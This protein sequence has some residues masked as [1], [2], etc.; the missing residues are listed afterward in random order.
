MDKIKQVKSIKD[1]DLDVNSL[2]KSILGDNSLSKNA[3]MKVIQDISEET[4]QQKD[5]Q[6]TKD[7][8]KET[9]TIRYKQWV[10]IKDTA[11]WEQ[12][13]WLLNY[14]MDKKKVPSPI[15]EVKPGEPVRWTFGT[16]R[17]TSEEF[18]EYIRTIKY[19]E[20]SKDIQ[21]IR[22]ELK[23]YDKLD[24]D[25]KP[26][27][28]L[29]VELLNMALAKCFR[30]AY[31]NVLPKVDV[32]VKG[33]E[34]KPVISDI[35]LFT[36]EYLGMLVKSIASSWEESKTE[37]ASVTK[38]TIDDKLKDLADMMSGM[39]FNNVDSQLGKISSEYQ[40][41]YLRDPFTLIRGIDY[42]IL[43]KYLE[44]QLKGGLDIL[45]V[46]QPDLYVDMVM[47]MLKVITL[48]TFL[49][50]SFY[51]QPEN[52]KA[53][54]AGY[55]KFLMYCQAMDLNLG[56]QGS[57]NALED[58]ENGGFYLNIYWCLASFISTWDN[59]FENLDIAK[60][61]H[62]ML[63]SLGEEVEQVE[64]TPEEILENMSKLIKG[65]CGYTDEAFIK[66]QWYKDDNNE[67]Y[68]E[69]EFINEWS[70]MWYIGVGAVKA[71]Y[72]KLFNIEQSNPLSIYKHL[73]SMGFWYAIANRQ[74]K[75]DIFYHVLTNYD[76]KEFWEQLS[77]T[78][79]KYNASYAS[80]SGDY[81]KDLENEDIYTRLAANYRF[82]NY[83][84]YNKHMQV[85]L[86]CNQIVPIEE[87]IYEHTVTFSHLE[88]LCGPT[89]LE[90]RLL[91]TMDKYRFYI[92]MEERVLRFRSEF[93]NR[94]EKQFNAESTNESEEIQELKTEIEDKNKLLEEYKTANQEFQEEYDKLKMQYTQLAKKLITLSKTQ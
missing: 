42:E 91:A 56:R 15:K 28:K 75:D 9:F 70:Y 39:V 81:R 1:F 34:E 48:H 78:S 44:L 86:M 43:D 3:L 92:L 46:A 12:A 30:T 2:N 88:D 93:D 23:I 45:V 29:P 31:I 73:D 25:L 61:Y 38:E 76:N 57:N 72:Y 27:I 32:N 5:F 51:N 66:V 74:C 53:C 7:T 80:D 49:N 77:D 16:K 58:F 4:N 71:N 83:T 90:N 60:T 17:F 13:K 64:A 84:F 14:I 36:E 79:V 50:D 89:A 94:V 47:F 22:R 24:E 68:I 87:D 6:E 82:K 37:L 11:K 40:Y 54:K 20:G 26:D 59:I 67:N 63:E 10:D 41:G 19:A 62:E 65:Q 52:W 33:S 21:T 55:D 69:K 8:G 85:S 18:I 35:F